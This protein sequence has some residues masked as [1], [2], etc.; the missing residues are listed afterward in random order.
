MRIRVAASGIAAWV[1]CAVVAG[2]TWAKADDGARKDVDGSAPGC[3][4]LGSE[5]V[6]VEGLGMLRLGDVAA[7]PGLSYEI[8]PNVMINGQP[9]VRLTPR[10]DCA[11]KGSDSVLVNGAVASRQGD[12]C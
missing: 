8:V 7:C 3:A 4:L 2:A 12:G 11:S 1:F 5:S 6:R 9:A 10:P